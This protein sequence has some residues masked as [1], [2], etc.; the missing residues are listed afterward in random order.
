MTDDWRMSQVLWLMVQNDTK[1]GRDV[2]KAETFRLYFANISSLRLFFQRHDYDNSIMY[3]CTV[4]GEKIS[5]NKYHYF[6]Y[7]G[8]IS[9]FFYEIFRDYSGH[10]LPLLLRILSSQLLLFR[11]STSL[12]IQGGPKKSEPQMLYT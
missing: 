10:N 2:N 4:C 6:Q 3:T 7:R 9:I 5:L 8:P 12:N 1:R 11:S